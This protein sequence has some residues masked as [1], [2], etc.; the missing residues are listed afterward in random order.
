[1]KKHFFFDMDGTLTRS[2]SMIN[3]TMAASL[4]GL[5]ANGGD[6]VVVSGATKDQMIKQL[7]DIMKEVV[8]MAQNG[9]HA[10]SATGEILW[11]N[12]L[13]DVQKNEVLNLVCKMIEQV[14]VEVTNHADLVEDRVCQISYS[15]IGHNAPLEDKEAADPHKEIRKGL[16]A[17]FPNEI[18]QLNNLGVQ[19]RI[20]GTTCVDFTTSHKGDNVKR[21]VEQMGWKCDEC[22]YVGDALFEGGNDHSVVGVIPTLA[23]PSH[24]ECEDAVRSFLM[25][26]DA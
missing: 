24:K 16:F 12:E 4:R 21:F 6:V 13:T 26:V 3:D 8:V 7:G 20:G 23:V 1:M 10:E 15:L 2:R 5:M 9:N 19:A 17:C 14:G 11:R 22:V 18:A 25:Q